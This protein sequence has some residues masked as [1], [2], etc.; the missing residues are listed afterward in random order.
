MFDVLLVVGLMLCAGI[1]YRTAN[2]GLVARIHR[3][4]QDLLHISDV[5][6]QMAE[7]QIK[8]FQK[9]SASLESLE[10][11]ILELSVPSHDSIMP[12]EKRHQVLALA[13]QGIA[14]GDIAKRL[15]APVG[16]AEV[17]L[18]LQKYMTKEDPRSLTSNGRVKNHV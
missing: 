15:K 7:V 16:E 1:Y 6:S 5:M 13:R 14:L 2:R 8:T 9:N 18:N 3:V 10:E 4:E 17:I 11:R 12:L